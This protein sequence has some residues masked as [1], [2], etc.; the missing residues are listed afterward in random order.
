MELHSDNKI[1]LCVSYEDEVTVPLSED[2]VREV[3]ELVLREEQVLASDGADKQP[4]VEISL[5]FCGDDRIGELNRDYRGID[6]P[7]DVLS[8]ALF[9]DNFELLHDKN[10]RAQMD[11]LVLGDIILAPH[12]IEEQAK[13]YGNSPADELRIMLVHGCL[14]LLGYDHIE[15]DEAELMETR[16]RHILSSLD[17]WGGTR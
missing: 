12:Y 11:E 13:E 3:L 17:S 14:H 7:T 4:P 6:R 2:E 15:D 1:E 9:E 8:F 10:L 16:E 5:L